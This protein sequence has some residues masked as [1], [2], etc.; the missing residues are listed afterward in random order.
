M[1]TRTD[2]AILIALLLSNAATAQSPDSPGDIAVTLSTADQSRLGIAT[3]RLEATEASD[4]VDATARVLDISA[5][6]LLEAE[7][8]TAA[9]AASASTSAEKRLALLAADDQIASIQV[10]EAARAQ[11][12]ADAA[13][14]LLA[15]RRIALEWGSGLAKLDDAGRQ[16]LINH[17]TTGKAALLRVDPLQSIPSK[18]VSVCLKSIDGL[19]PVAT[20][21]L[22]MAA[23]ADAR[24][25]TTGLLVLVRDEPAANFPA[26]RIVAAEI[27]TGRLQVGVLLPR[28]S[29]IRIDGSTWVYLQRGTEQFVRREVYAPRLLDAGWFVSERFAPGDTIVAS[30]SGS[31]LAI[32]RSDEAIE[33]D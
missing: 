10:L 16:R 31:L 25:Q 27:D 11:A 12:R 7:I 4:I 5:L 32:E 3:L 20:E 19:A 8:E 17:V 18:V 26:G 21:L 29:L 1:R 24:R 22:G 6:A 2:C 23:G 15:R 14:L 13:R 33:A 28:A 9:A 30:G